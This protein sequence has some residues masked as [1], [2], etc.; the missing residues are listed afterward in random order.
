MS[1]WEQACSCPASL[2]HIRYMQR[3][4][5]RLPRIVAVAK[6]LYIAATISDTAYRS[7]T[8]SHADFHPETGEE[9]N[10]VVNDEKL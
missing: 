3:Q 6:R 5:K 2:Q 10:R 7:R 8:F 9:K 1:A 4:A